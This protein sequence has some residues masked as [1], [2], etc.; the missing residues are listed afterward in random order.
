[1]N[2]YFD[3]RDSIGWFMSIDLLY[4]TIAIFCLSVIYL[5]FWRCPKCKH[6]FSM[7]K[8]MGNIPIFDC[9]G[10]CGFEPEKYLTENSTSCDD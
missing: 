9:C 7:S 10:S 5:T 1:M 4:L 3:A 8:E 2:K 6:F